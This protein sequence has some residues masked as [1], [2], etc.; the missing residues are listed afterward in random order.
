MKWVEGKFNISVSNCSRL[1]ILFP[2][3]TFLFAQESHETQAKENC[4]SLWIKFPFT[5]SC[6][7]VIDF[8]CI[9][10][11]EAAKP[12]PAPPYCDNSR[13][14]KTVSTIVKRT[15]Y[16]DGQRQSCEI[17]EL[18][19][20]IFEVS[21]KTIMILH[22]SS[23]L[24]LSNSNVVSHH[25]FAATSNAP[26]SFTF[27]RYADCATLFSRSLVQ[28]NVITY[29]TTERTA[30]NCELLQSCIKRIL[31]LAFFLSFSFHDTSKYL[32]SS[33]PEE[34]RARKLFHQHKDARHLVIIFCL[35]NSPSCSWRMRKKR[36]EVSRSL[37][38][39]S[40]W[41]HIV[42]L[43]WAAVA[44]ALAWR[45]KHTAGRAALDL[46]EITGI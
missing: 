7:L 33:R 44:F 10:D 24:F 14:L 12:P 26:H 5:F 21:P 45:R 6:L 13:R 27:C 28:R 34:K 29:I 22:T 38:L 1:N 30:V 42:L 4:E 31:L 43:C 37:I 32:D 46:T 16:R 40:D 18:S 11:D 39:H 19:Y 9:V 23:L 3:P 36:D 20:S 35:P 25:S 2:Y 17:R 8:S 41:W 15:S